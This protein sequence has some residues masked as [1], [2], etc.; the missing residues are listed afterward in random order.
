MNKKIKINKEN[1]I[2]EKINKKEDKKSVFWY[3]YRIQILISVS[4][5]LLLLASFATV[6]D[7]FLNLLQY[8]V[9][10]KLKMPF[11]NLY[12]MDFKLSFPKFF[13]FDLL[14]ILIILVLFFILYA[15]KINKIKN[16][17]DFTDKLL[18]SLIIIILYFFF[19]G[20]VMSNKLIVMQIILFIG[21]I[22]Y[23]LMYSFYNDIRNKINLSQK[24]YSG[25]NELKILI[26]YSLFILILNI[27]DYKSW[28]YSYIGDEWSF[29]EYAKGIINGKVP[30]NV[31]S[32]SGVYGYHPVM[33]SIWQ[34]F[35]MF[36]TDRGLF[37]WKLSS[38]IILP[39][40]IIPFYIWN[41]M[42]FNRTVAIISTAVF[43][44]ANAMMAF[45]HIGYNN[46]QTI[47]FYV[48]TL[49]LLE[50]AIRKK[51]NF[52]FIL[53]SIVIGLGFYT[54]YSSRIMIIIAALYIALHPDNKKIKLAK[55]ILPF[56]L[57]VF[58]ISPLI[59][60]PE[61]FHHMLSQTAISGSE[62]QK[63]EERPVYFFLNFIHSFFAFMSKSK[64]SHFMVD[65]LVDIIS[66]IGVLYGL[67][68]LFVSFIKDW[69]AKFLLLSYFLFVLFIGALHQYHYPVN[70]RLIFL[71]PLLATIS[72]LGLSRMAILITYFKKSKALYI[73]T[74]MII[75]FIIFILNYTVFHIIMPQK[76]RFTMQA[77]IMKF[78]QT[79]Q[80]SEKIVVA[81]PGIVNLHEIIKI[82]NLDKKTNIVSFDMFDTMLKEGNVKNKVIIFD[83]SVVDYEN[84]L[85]RLVK[86]GFTY[87]DNEN[88][89]NL[90]YIY[91]FKDDI[92]YYN[93]F[94]EL[95]TTGKTG[96][97]LKTGKPEIKAKEKEI[98]QI[99]DKN[100]I[101]KVIKYKSN[102][103]MQKYSLSIYK[104]FQFEKSY[105]MMR[106]SEI[107]NYKITK[108]DFD[109]KLIAP[110]DLLYDEKL[111]LL[112][113]ADSGEKKIFKFTRQKNEIFKLELKIS[114]PGKLTGD[115]SNEI[116][117]ILFI[118]SDIAKEILYVLDSIEGKVYEI[119]YE[120]NLL[121]E[122]VQ[123]DY[124]KNS[125]D[126]KFI[127][128]TE[129]FIINNPEE[130]IFIIFDKNWNIKNAYSTIRGYGEG[131]MNR[132]VSSDL[133]KDNYLLI[134]DSLN[135][136]IQLFDN[137]LKYI[138]NYRSGICSRTQLPDIL[139]FYH[140]VKPYFIVTQPVSKKIFIFLLNE[141]AFRFINLKENKDIKFLNPSKITI[142]GNDF[143]MLDNIGKFIVRLQMPKDFVFEKIDF[144]ARR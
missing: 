108:L 52:Y 16:W 135:G 63:P 116:T 80:N 40:T 29:Y 128:K 93:G 83:N 73:I 4:F 102:N 15:K 20:F 53:T 101:K 61:F 59:L 43:S 106:N 64:N 133:T 86:P 139:F 46:I 130:N 96:Y 22:I 27:Y 54:F 75:C 12:F 113:V 117:D 62:I 114:I 58:I 107:K 142:C 91:D 14:L 35:I 79:Y 30:L 65:G 26:F 17:D 78:L 8:Q 38:A 33:S 125:T 88:R 112:F 122:V 24:N 99:E 2:A 51:S 76:L 49:Y 100:T 109:V 36:I 123:S 69:R 41:K 136:R 119:N 70:T 7:S 82:Y 77:Y 3:K 42:V 140:P 90:F 71:V 104:N 18:F 131:Q 67:I 144:P 28:K 44:L 143:Y 118:T 13:A 84:K 68:W 103:K 115:E 127:E 47:F 39:L 141:D 120:G 21:L 105:R 124:I 34:A 132:P 126:I 111:N 89:K 129:C 32:E 134:A 92:D 5:I 138:K 9:F 94:Y 37:G 74:I 6:Y 56:I 1:N 97:V 85:S 110:S 72:G 98:K 11:S 10:S 137:N 31:F 121:R 23:F 25:G 81:S 87:T 45:S 95:W 50:I 60:R 66:A 55:F 57:Y 48:I 19:I